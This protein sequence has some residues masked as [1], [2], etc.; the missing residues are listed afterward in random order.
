MGF[1]AAFFK[2]FQL[3]NSI[4]AGGGASVLIYAAGA[5]LVAANVV[6]PGLGIPLTMGM[7][8]AVALVGGH[9][10]TALMPDSVKQQVDALGKK[11]GV[12]VIG[13]ENHGAAD[14]GFLILHNHPLR[15]R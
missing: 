13:P 4:A 2:N 10:V 9:V 6:V 8:G 7:V 1:L 3:T 5:A 11:I 15:P 12:Q 14:R